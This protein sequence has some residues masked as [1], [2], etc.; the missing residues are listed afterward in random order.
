MPYKRVKRPASAMR[1][2]V[3]RGSAAPFF[4]KKQKKKSV[5]VLW[6]DRTSARGLGFPQA[7]T[8]PAG[9][10]T[11]LHY[12]VVSDMTSTGTSGTFM[13]ERFYRLNSLYDPDA[14]LGGAQPYYYDTLFGVNGT[15]APYRQWRVLKTRIDVQWYNDNTASGAAMMVGACV[16]LDLNTTAG[17]VA[18]SQLMMQRP[19]TRIVPL[20][21][22]SSGQG[23]A[24]FTFY[25]DHKQ[26]L[27]V[28]DMKDADDQIGYSNN[29]PVGAEVS[30]GLFTFPI[31]TGNVSTA[32]QV[33]YR[34]H[35]TYTVECRM[36]NTVV[37]S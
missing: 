23:V 11:K 31:D 4:A 17:T 9:M 6:L 3:R 10:V 12:N 28:K 18:A 34:L 24:G 29:S 36:L 8:F 14:S 20:P 25:V 19:H 5:P 32:V 26:L 27:G 7:N 30:L 37:E 16:A 33:W 21:V 1:T 35:I 13:P 22:M 15:S 2:T